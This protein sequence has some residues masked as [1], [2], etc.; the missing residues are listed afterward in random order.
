VQDKRRILIVDNHPLVRRGLVD[1]IDREPDLAV[2]TAVA[3]WEE[4]LDAITSLRPDLVITGLSLCCDEGRNLLSGIR[5]AQEDLPVLALTVVDNS[6]VACRHF[7]DAAS[8]YVSKQETGE[9]LLAAMRRVLDGETYLG[10][11]GHRGFGA[12]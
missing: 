12:A 9:A 6:E 4:A 10:S 1:L 2:C 8:G 7:G 5:S 3:S 11:N